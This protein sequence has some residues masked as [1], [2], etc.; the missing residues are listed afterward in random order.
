MSVIDLRSDTITQP[1]EEMRQAMA[2]AEVGDDVYR[3]DPS[4]NRLE[5]RSAEI[6]GKEA[7]LLTASGTMSNLIATLD[8]LPPR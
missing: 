7:G 2:K 5:Q 3:E 1:T 4:I 8:L 6:L